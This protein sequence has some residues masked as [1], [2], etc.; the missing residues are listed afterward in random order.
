M[1]FP[2][3]YLQ[4]KFLLLLLSV[5]IF[6]T[7]LTIVLILLRLGSGHSDY[8]I[9]CRDC[10]NIQEVG[11]FTKGGLTDILAFMLYS[12]FILGVSTLLSM[13]LFTIH[14]QLAVVVAALG[15]LLLVL[16]L[17]VSFAL[18]SLR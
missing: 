9:Q 12:V 6:V 18:L 16:S 13:R 3:K 4:D 11:R 17:I 8:L 5:N 10:S 7:V 15:S 2:K 1:E 14:R